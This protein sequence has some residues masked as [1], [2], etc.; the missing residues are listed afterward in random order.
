MAE[1]GDGAA[2]LVRVT[3]GGM[4]ESVHRGHAVICDAEGA[5]VAAWGDPG[6]VILPRSACKMVQALPLLE[7]GAGDGLS[8]AR[9]ALACASHQGAAVHRRMVAD[10][11]A[12]LD[13]AEG[14][15]RCGPQVPRDEAERDRLIL[16]DAAPCRLHNNCSGKH[17]G[18][19][20][21]A[22]RLGGGPD[23]VAIDHP[24]QRAVRLAFE[25]V[26]GMESP[27][28]GIDG[29]S[30]PNFATRIEALAGA[31]ARF[32][33]ASEGGNGRARAMARLRGAMASAPELVA[34]EGRACTDL[35]RAMAG[36][37]VVKTGAEGVFVAILPEARRG[38]AVKI[39][40]G[41]TRAAEAVIAA[42]LVREGA[43]AGENSVA[44]RLMHGPI[45]NWDGV[46]TGAY[47][48]ALG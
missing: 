23:Y 45:R 36:R 28:W 42:L 20:Q 21:L 11:L 47:E 33:A 25:E 35:I 37:G 24:V 17:A 7:S 27:G 9:L 12:E 13:L 30:A 32:A 22:G 16:G 2:E 41:A 34:G 4:V 1:V 19:L 40:D 3:R 10:W 43:L 26:T 5:A 44:R 39:V 48:V 46:E 18:F 29:C 8:D 6:S 38:I 15:L 14:D 31:M